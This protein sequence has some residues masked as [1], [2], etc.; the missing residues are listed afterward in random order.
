MPPNHNE[1]AF[2]NN[3]VNHVVVGR[4]RNVKISWEFLFTNSGN[5]LVIPLILPTFFIEALPALIS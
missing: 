2:V 3:R 5:I 4:T 1:I